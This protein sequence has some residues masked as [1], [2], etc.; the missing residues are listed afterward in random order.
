VKGKYPVKIQGYDNFFNYL[1][2]FVADLPAMSLR[3][4]APKKNSTRETRVELK[5]AIQSNAQH[6]RLQMPA[7]EEEINASNLHS[8]EH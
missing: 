1:G 2:W 7:S 6:K 8:A 5:E 4:S 3:G